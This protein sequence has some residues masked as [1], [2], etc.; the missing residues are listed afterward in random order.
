M[1]KKSAKVQ[2]DVSSIEK[3]VSEADECLIVTSTKGQIDV[4][5]VKGLTYAHQAKGLL[6]GAIDKYEANVI[7]NT[8]NVINTNVINKVEEAK[9]EAEN[10]GEE[11]KVLIK[12]LKN[13]KV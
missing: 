4:T 3:L 6:S 13:K 1:S 12:E 11:I 7:L 10:K 8:L 9:A 5:G 2:E